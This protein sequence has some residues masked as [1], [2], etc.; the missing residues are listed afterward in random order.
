MLYRVTA[1][2]FD[3]TTDVPEIYAP[4]FVQAMVRNQ[5]IGRTYAAKDPDHLVEVVS[6][7]T[8]WCLLNLAYERVG[9][10]M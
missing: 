5:V 8:G 2:E 6:D 4:D 9:E 1:A 10:E 3:F 7:D